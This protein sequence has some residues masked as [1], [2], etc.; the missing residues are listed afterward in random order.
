MQS[1]TGVGGAGGGGNTNVDGGTNTGGG[2]GGGGDSSAGKTGGSGI[3]ILRM[4]TSNYSGTYS[5]AGV[6]VGTDGS[7]TYLVFTQSGSYTA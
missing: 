7:D 1:G 3:V 4:A 2:A 6:T 5:G